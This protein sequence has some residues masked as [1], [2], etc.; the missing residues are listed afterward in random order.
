MYYKIKCR[1]VRFSIL[2]QAGEGT[3]HL[4]RNPFGVVHDKI[5]KRRKNIYIGDNMICGIIHIE[6][7]PLEE[8][9]RSARKFEGCP[10]VMSW[11]IKGNMAY[12]QLVLPDGKRW[13]AEYIEEHPEQTF[14]GSRVELVFADNVLKPALKM[15]IPEVLDDISPCGAS[16][17]TCPV[18]SRCMACPAT[19]CYKG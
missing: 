9:E 5:K 1:D 3:L 7:S 6:Y 14:G 8:A 16:C 10:H 15:L 2:Q 12:V 13:W 4:F 11:A 19:V 17:S 18:Y